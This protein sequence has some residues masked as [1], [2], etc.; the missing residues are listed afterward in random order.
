MN[1][2]VFKTSKD[3]DLFVASRICETISKKPDALL[4]LAAGHSPLGVFKELIRMNGEGEIDFSS[5]YFVGLDEW[6]GIGRNNTD[7]CRNFMDQNFFSLINV[8]HARIVFFDGESEDLKKECSRADQF[9]ERRGGIDFMLLGVG[10]NGHLG[11]NEPGVDPALKAHVT[12][13]DQVTREVSAK[14]YFRK[15]VTL[16][17]GITLG[18]KQI[19]ETKDV[20]V[21]LN[22]SHKAG[23]SSR[24]FNEEIS[25]QIPASLIR[26]LP[27]VCF[28]L[29][30]DAATF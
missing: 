24:I 8:N 13:I 9:I 19:M 4:C 17:R 15:S 6:V 21:I 14:K 16:D 29:D 27:Q 23:I 2:R 3:S 1:L 12:S 30:Q 20:V 11:L 28:C 10:M 25:E 26:E 22:G 18:I 5:C 7:S